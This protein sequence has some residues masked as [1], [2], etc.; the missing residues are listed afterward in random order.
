MISEDNVR[1]NRRAFCVTLFHRSIAARSPSAR[2]RL[3]L[4]SIG[5]VCFY[6]D[7]S[8]SFFMD[9][10]SGDICAYAIELV[11]S[12]RRF[13]NQYEPAISDEVEQRRI[14][15]VQSCEWVRVLAYCPNLYLIEWH[16]E[17]PVNMARLS[18]GAKPELHAPVARELLHR[19]SARNCGTT[20]RRPR[21]VPEWRHTLSYPPQLRIL[22]KR[23]V[24]LRAPRRQ[25]A[26]PTLS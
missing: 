1:A 8:E 20:G 23:M 5:P 18:G 19:W 26:L 17:L 4:M 21:T 6:S 14:I 16:D 12:M 25:L 10:L 15:F 9:E 2:C 24:E 7:C 11:G 22:S 3:S 13:T